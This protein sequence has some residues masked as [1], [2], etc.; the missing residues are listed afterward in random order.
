V[1]GIALLH[2]DRLQASSQ[3]AEAFGSP[4]ISQPAAPVYAPAPDTDRSAQ[5]LEN[6][7]QVLTTVLLNT[8]RPAPALPSETPA[9]SESNGQPRKRLYGLPCGKCGAYFTSDQTSCSVCGT[10]RAGKR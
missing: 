10:P 2:P 3:M 9:A 5:A 7:A 4:A 8:Q 1:V 6:L